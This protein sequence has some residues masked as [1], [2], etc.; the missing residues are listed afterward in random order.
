MQIGIAEFLEKVS[1]LKKNEEK[2]EALKI[3]DS[4]VLRVILQ[5][6]FDPDVK[7]DL[8]SG[9]PP[10]KVN[11]LVDQ[12]QI[13]IRE[14]RKIQYFVK[15]LHPNLSSTKREMMFIELLENVD[16]EDAKLLI[17]IKDKKFPWKGITLD[18]VK[19]GLP[20]LIP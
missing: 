18:I 12:Q 4:Y 6:A 17:A 19:E 7:F 5:A 20:G 2:V 10:Y 1:K 15:D 9:T 11:T 16:P 13:L 8:P 14:A 3:N